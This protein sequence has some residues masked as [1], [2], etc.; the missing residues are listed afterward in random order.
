MS[1]PAPRHRFIAIEGV[2]GAGKTSLARRLA[3]HYGVEGLFER[4]DENPFLARFYEEGGRHALAAQLFFLFQR[5]EQLREL[6]QLDLFRSGTVADF[7]FDKDRLFAQLTLSSDE[8]SLYDKIFQT[9][10]PQAP[11]PDLVIYL[12]APLATLRQRIERRAR[13]YEASLL[14]EPRSAY[15]SA[16]SEAYNQFFHHYE[17]APLFIVNSEHLNFVDRP[18]DFALLV[19]RIEAMRGPREYFNADQG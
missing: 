14:D 19:E 4:P 6:N 1:T 8:M 17:E 10:K 12:Q 16:L 2:I 9:L 11:T 18:A 3:E 5:V 13:P 15:L 7:L